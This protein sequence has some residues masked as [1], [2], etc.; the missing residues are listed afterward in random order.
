MC[1]LAQQDSMGNTPD[2]PVHAS[3]LADLLNKRFKPDLSLAKAFSVRLSSLVYGAKNTKP[4]I[5][6]NK[7]LLEVSPLIVEVN[8]HMGSRCKQIMSFPTYWFY[9]L[10]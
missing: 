2:D 9:F 1:L 5:G 10:F 4:G 6:T 3:Y 7:C 8:K